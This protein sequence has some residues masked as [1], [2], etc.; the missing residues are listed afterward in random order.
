MVGTFTSA[1]ESELI[2]SVCFQF[3]VTPHEPKNLPKCSHILCQ[4]CLQRMTEGGLKTIKCPQC[5]RISSVPEDGIDGLTT[6]LIVRNLAERHPKGIKQHKEHVKNE[7]HQKK[8]QYARRMMKVKESEK[9]IHSSIKCEESEIE[10]SVE[11]V[12]AKAKELV[13]QL[14]STCGLTQIQQ[15]IALLET[16]MENIEA[17]QSKLETMTD[18]EFQIQT[19]ALTSQLGKLQID[20]PSQIYNDQSF[21]KFISNAQ[22][23]KIVKPKRLKLMQS[24]GEF[25]RAASIA[26]NTNGLLAVCD[27][28][29]SIPFT[30]VTVFQSEHL[31]FKKQFHFEGK[32][33]VKGT[34][35]DIAISHTD[36]YMVTKCAAGFDVHSSNG[37]Y[38]KTVN[39]IDSKPSHKVS[40]VTGSITTTVDGRILVGS[41]IQA[42]GEESYTPI[43]TVHDAAGNL[44]KTI[45][46]SITPLCIADIRGTHVAVSHFPRNKVCVYDLQSGK[47]TLNLDI[48]MPSGICYDEESE[49][50]L[51]VRATKKNEQGRPVHGSGVIEQ[52]CSVTG[53]LVACLV[54]GLQ[55]PIGIT[56]TGD[57]R[58]AVTDATTVKLYQMH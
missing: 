41:R 17:S 16:Q 36:K 54:R 9:Q 48:P 23:G 29:S 3:Y 8:E 32:N 33:V 20:E 6:S 55:A 1:A 38:E 40:V 18:E 45:P 14:H 39:V 28:S 21:G 56:L 35:L 2:C 25:Q 12:M 53:K 42:K 34:P 50:M 47:E 15:Q 26:T 31:Q 43:T 46:I 7:L 4:V 22:L 49:C 44:L 19:D 37:K 13:N 24:F 11:T 52:Y 5:N 10:K 30:Q 27:S 57:N 51:I 58:L